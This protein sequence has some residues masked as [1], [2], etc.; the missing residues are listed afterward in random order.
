MLT[1]PALLIAAGLVLLGAA[2]GRE[3]PVG[4]LA[5][6]GGE[7]S[8]RSSKTSLDVLCRCLSAAISAQEDDGF[9]SVGL[10][11]AFHARCGSLDPAPGMSVRAPWLTERWVDPR[12]RLRACPVGPA[13]PV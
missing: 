12:T 10:N 7:R 2:A 1:K 13:P 6:T 8:C 4:E 9:S 3:T 11:V 5:P